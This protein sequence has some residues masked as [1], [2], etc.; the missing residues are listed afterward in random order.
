MHIRKSH[1]LPFPPQS[2][3]TYRGSGQV[4]PPL[5]TVHGL[6]RQYSRE[7]VE[8]GVA[9]HMRFMFMQH[10]M[11]KDTVPTLSVS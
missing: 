8:R 10:S 1:L 3:P 2:I 11:R 9:R 4:Q 6:V 5:I 7:S